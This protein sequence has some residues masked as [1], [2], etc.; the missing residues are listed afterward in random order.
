MQYE[1]RHG[2]TALL[3]RS[4]RLLKGINLLWIKFFLLAVFATMFVGHKRPMYKALNLNPT[5]Y[6]MRVFEITTTV[7]KQVFPVLLDIKIPIF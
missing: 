6:D 1:F 7:S 3:M 2:E 5:E 4:D